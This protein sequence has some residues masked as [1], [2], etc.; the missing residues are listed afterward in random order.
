MELTRFYFQRDA[1]FF[2]M[3]RRFAGDNAAA[4]AAPLF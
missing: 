1:A 3:A 4:L 2:A